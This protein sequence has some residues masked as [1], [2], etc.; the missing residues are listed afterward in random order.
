MFS[1]KD[2]GD[3][4]RVFRQH[5]LIPRRANLLGRCHLA[6]YCASPRK[7]VVLCYWLS[8]AL[9]GFPRVP[10]LVNRKCRRYQGP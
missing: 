9:V 10:W 2:V 5:G 7:T 1:I 8:I 4:A 3:L 6:I